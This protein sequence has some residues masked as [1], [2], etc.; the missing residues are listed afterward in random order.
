MTADAITNEAQ[1]YDVTL[2][3]NDSDFNEFSAR[4]LRGAAINSADEPEQAK[5]EEPEHSRREK[6]TVLKITAATATM[7]ITRPHSDRER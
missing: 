7:T 3:W 2:Q 1:T 5:A 6:E 4:V